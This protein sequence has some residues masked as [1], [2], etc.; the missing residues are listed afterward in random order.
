MPCCALGL[1]AT[2]EQAQPTSTV[3]YLLSPR[4][5]DRPWR[6]SARTAAT[7]TMS[8]LDSAT[9]QAS[10]WI[11]SDAPRTPW[12]TPAPSFPPLPCPLSSP[13]STRPEAAVAMACRRR[14]SHRRPRSSPTVSGKLRLASQLHRRCQAIRAGS[15]LA[16][17][18]VIFFNLGAARASSPTPSPLQL[19]SS[20]P[21]LRV[22]PAVSIR[23]PCLFPARLPFA[24]SRYCHHLCRSS[25]PPALLAAVATIVVV[26]RPSTSPCSWPPPIGAAQRRPATLLPP[27]PLALD[28]S[29]PVLRPPLLLSPPSFRPPPRLAYHRHHRTRRSNARSNAPVRASNGAPE[30]VF[31]SK[32]GNRR[33]GCGHRRSAGALWP[34]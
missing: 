8:T 23:V 28:P 22:P 21:G 30:G 26:A 9:L 3:V 29:K 6:R 27:C 5:S 15:R 14:C 24:R 2:V 32:P 1:S 33:Y 10:G 7:A 4:V 25:M 19:L 17:D 34:C 12:R 20:S 16:P 11:R 13:H 18:R 31:R